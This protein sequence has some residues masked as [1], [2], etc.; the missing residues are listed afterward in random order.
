MKASL[1]LATLSLTWGLTG[2]LFLA[3]AVHA[4]EPVAPPAKADLSRGKQ[5]AEQVCAA[6][7]GADGNSGASA[8]P[9]LAGQHPEYV[10]KQLHEF[11][12]G[13]RKNAVMAGMA[14]ALNDQDIKNVAAYYAAQKPKIIGAHDEK[15][16]KDG[17]KIYRGGDMARGLPACIACHGPHGNGMA[18]QYPRLGGQHAAYTVAQLKAYRSG[19]RANDSAAVMRTISAKLTDAEINALGQYIQGL[20]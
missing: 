14:A 15:A 8:N 17:A 19:E 16:L 2:G 4:A 12:K 13:L 1:L 11:K 20:R 3:T 10:V 5:I 9:S 18:A 6:C 7:H